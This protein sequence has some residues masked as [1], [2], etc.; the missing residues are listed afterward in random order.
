MRLLVMADDFTGAMDTGVQFSKKGIRTFVSTCTQLDFDQV[1][2]DVQV[3]VIDTESRHIS[4]GEAYEIVHRLVLKAREYGIQHVYK[5]I[6]STFRGNVGQELKAVM[7]A[8]EGM[9]FMCVPAYPK[10]GRTTIDSVQ[11]VDGIPLHQTIYSKD[12]LNPITT[13]YIP[14]IL[15][16]QPGI[17][18]V[19][20]TAEGRLITGLEDRNTI[21][22]FD[23]QSNGDLINTGKILSS[24]KKLSL[25]AGCA[26]FAEYLPEFIDFEKCGASLEQVKAENILVVSGSINRDSIK[27]TLYGEMSGFESIVLTSEQKNAPGYMETIRGK[28]LA[29]GIAGMIKRTGKVIVKTV[30]RRE[31]VDEAG[32]PVKVAGSLGALTRLVLDCAIECA[33]VVFGGDTAIHIMEAVECSGLLPVEEIVPGVAVSHAVCKYGKIILVSKAGGFGE[34]DVLLKIQDYLKGKV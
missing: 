32:D 19:P 29:A 26:G 31:E 18:A 11:F 34:E 10:T 1:E 9:P 13:G 20:A 5:K 16:R 14:E 8:W 24:R 33:L 4:P 23:G 2:Q 12:L 22:I 3:L 30:N 28:E 15:M 27:Q 25:T 6:D 17:G 7:D 21:Y